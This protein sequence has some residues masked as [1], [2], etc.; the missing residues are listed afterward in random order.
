MDLA[1]RGIAQIFRPEFRYK[2]AELILKDLQETKKVTLRLLDQS[3]YEQMQE[4]MKAIDHVNAKHSKDKI[5]FGVFKT[6]EK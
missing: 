6:K 4:L 3:R 5:Q 2:K 1:Q